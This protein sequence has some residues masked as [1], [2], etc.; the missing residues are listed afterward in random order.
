[1]E[2][3]GQLQAYELPAAAWESDILPRRVAKYGPDLLDR[4][5][6][7]GEVVWGRF[8]PHPALE[9]VAPEESTSRR[10]RP[11]RV[12]PLALFRR[13]DAGAL[14][15]LS[16]GTAPADPSSLSHVAREVAQVLRT[17]GASFF[18][19]L[20]HSTHRLASEVEDGLW[21]LVAAGLVTGDGF[22][23]LR[24][25]V[26]PKRRRGEGRGRYARPRHA[27]GRW[28]LL[29][30]PPVPEGAPTPAEAC[31]RQL[32][33]RWGVVCRDLLARESLTPPWRDLLVVLRRMEAR[34]EV[35]G[36]RFV[37]ALLG[38]QFA[39]PEAV[40]VLRSV[41]RSAPLVGEIHVSAAD[42]LNL[43][44]IVLP[45]ARVSPLSGER[46]RLLAISDAA[47]TG[48]IA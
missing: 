48:R 5:C 15:A 8:S 40:D 19:E 27:A 30:F 42:P 21:E 16:T 29:R 9:R 35:R 37:A 28:A 44:G 33:K 11:N 1:M 3:I 36:G 2:V 46:V 43:A 7:A 26:D 18:N 41:R 17:Q 14:A 32:L 25:L 47:A 23:N 45:G 22:E 24:A 4:L 31:A 39:L 20:T 34:G 10:V 12:A 6:L 38:E 13:V